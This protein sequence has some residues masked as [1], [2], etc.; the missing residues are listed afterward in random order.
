MYGFGGGMGGFGGGGPQFQNAVGQHLGNMMGGGYAPSPGGMPQMNYGQLG[1]G[2]SNQFG[3]PMVDKV[4]AHTMPLVTNF[5]DYSGG[6]GNMGQ[7]ISGRLPGYGSMGQQISGQMP[8]GGMPNFGGG[9]FYQPE[10]TA[11]PMPGYGFQPRPMPQRTY[12]PG[13]FPQ[14]DGGGAMNPGFGGAMMP[15][16]D[17]G[18]MRNPDMQRQYANNDQYRNAKGNLRMR[19]RD[20]GQMAGQAPPNSY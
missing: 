9:G 2:V 3:G 20:G 11:M 14:P 7:Q 8:F 17:G 19:Y 18:P 13:G 15:Q 1:Q 16:P 6:Y 5:P 4:S 12:R 10:M